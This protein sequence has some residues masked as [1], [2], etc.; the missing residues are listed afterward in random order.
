MATTKAAGEAVYETVLAASSAIKL[1]HLN[2]EALPRLQ[3]VLDAP[4]SIFFRFG[5]NGLG[6]IGGTLQNDMPHYVVEFRNRDPIWNLIVEADPRMDIFC[7]V[8]AMGIDRFRQCEIYHE[9][10]KHY[11]VEELCLIRF[12]QAAFGTP[13]T[14][15]IMLFRSPQQL[16]FGPK[17]I[18]VIKTV[19][20]A[21][22]AAVQRADRFQTLEREK[23][24]LEAL[25]R[26]TA[27][28][29]CLALDLEGKL[30]W[31]SP[32]ARG[33]LGPNFDPAHHIPENLIHE[34]KKLGSLLTG[35]HSLSLP[36]VTIGLQL[37][38][39]RELGADLFLW[40]GEGESPAIAVL[41][42]PQ[43]QKP[44]ISSIP[45][46]ERLSPA[47]LR[48]LDQ[49][50]HGLSNRDIAKR[51]FI[52]VETVRSHIKN[53]LAKF[54]VSSRTEAVSRALNEMRS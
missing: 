3:G 12:T 36:K 54:K 33:L 39:G 24:G 30:L 46:I 41:L 35:R 17:E 14:T 10:Y 16:P 22:S 6:P 45:S 7:P 38:D 20:P 9:F 48:V 13:G 26:R 2:K 43:L 25:I 37:L 8:Q 40:R 27:T 49:L 42:E 19:M 5:E 53:I 31:I 52:S 15:G 11:D 23:L 29:P 47:E 1:D 18:S 44:M 32:M 51:L 34:A 50:I 4:G 21:F 28:Q